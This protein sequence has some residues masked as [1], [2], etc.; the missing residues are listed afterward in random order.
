[1]QGG[2]PSLN[3]DHFSRQGAGFVGDEAV[4]KNYLKNNI[5]IRG[6]SVKSISG[7]KWRFLKKSR[8]VT[9]NLVLNLLQDLTILGSL[10]SLIL[11]DAEI[12]S[13]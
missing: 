8:C 13:A 9:L 5:K 10:N 11:L 7:D 6:H 2:L 3:P 4:M 12:N 1:V